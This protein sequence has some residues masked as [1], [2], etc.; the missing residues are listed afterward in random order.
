MKKN[1][2]LYRQGDVIIEYI[3]EL[4]SNA[5]PVSHNGKIVLAYG[6]VTGHSHAVLDSEHKVEEY[7]TDTGERFLRIMSHVEIAH[8][9]HGNYFLHP[10]I[11]SIRQKREYVPKAIPRR[12]TD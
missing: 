11:V 1:V 2:N 8:E 4:P 10:G 12:V 6:E 7:K 5:T 9:E 3:P